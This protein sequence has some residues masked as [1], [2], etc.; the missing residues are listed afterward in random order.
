MLTYS[1]VVVAADEFEDA[2]AE[3]EDA[4]ADVD[5]DAEDVDDAED[6]ADDAE[7][8][9]VLVEET[10]VADRLA[11]VAEP[12]AEDSESDVSVEESVD[13]VGNAAM[14]PSLNDVSAVSDGEG[15]GDAMSSDEDVLAGSAS[16]ATTFAVD[17]VAEE[18]DDVDVVA[19]DAKACDAEVAVKRERRATSITCKS[20]IDA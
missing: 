20:S 3:V 15:E 7:E 11:E 2:D 12:D 4:D 5:A 1:T 8:D 6:D 9:E 18:A 16:E 17:D 10:E 13:A 14:A 19:S